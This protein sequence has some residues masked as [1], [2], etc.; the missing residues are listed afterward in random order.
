MPYSPGVCPDMQIK[1]S[2]REHARETRSA[3]CCCRRCLCRAFEGWIV[4]K[5]KHDDGSDDGAAC[6]EG[7]AGEIGS[8][9]IAQLPKDFGPEIP[10]EIADGTDGGN[11]CRCSRPAEKGSRKRPESWKD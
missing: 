2:A 8:G 6:E 3:L 5:H 1:R 7:Q 4:T 11:A 10:A 9:P